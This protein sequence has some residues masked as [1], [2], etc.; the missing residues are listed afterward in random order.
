VDFYSL[1]RK[2]FTEDEGF[3][4][5]VPTDHVDNVHPA[6][7]IILWVES[8]IS[9]GEHPSLLSTTLTQWTISLSI[10]ATYQYHLHFFFQQFN[11]EGDSLLMINYD[12]FL[13]WV[14]SQCI[15]CT[16]TFKFSIK[17]WMRF[18]SWPTHIKN[19]VDTLSANGKQ[20]NIGTTIGLAHQYL[21]LVTTLG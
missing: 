16:H 15:M 18:L 2:I 3:A 14:A 20:R 17:W 9:R 19:D 12:G 1:F 11:L 21:S 7:C 8:T 6:G 5:S 10:F 13:T 4:D